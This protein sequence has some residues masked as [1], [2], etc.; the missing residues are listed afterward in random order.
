MKVK[1]TRKSVIFLFIDNQ[2]G[3]YRKGKSWKKRTTDCNE[4][5]GKISGWK[6]LCENGK[7]RWIMREVS[8][9]YMPI[10]PADL[11]IFTININNLV[12]IFAI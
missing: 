2:I 10:A 11:L 6:F 7:E 3:K 9:K 4:K 5:K 12:L 1:F 8:I